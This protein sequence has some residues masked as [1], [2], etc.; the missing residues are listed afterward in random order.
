MI[1]YHFLELESFVSICVKN[2]QKS[3][4]SRAVPFKVRLNHS[5]ALTQPFVSPQMSPF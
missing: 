1:Y 2:R 5:R 4:D 3:G